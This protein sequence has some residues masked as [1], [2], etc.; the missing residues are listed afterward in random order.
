MNMAQVIVGSKETKTR[1][2]EKVKVDKDKSA[3][4]CEVEDSR[5]PFGGLYAYRTINYARKSS[6]LLIF[7]ALSLV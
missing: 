6:D 3:M 5:S 7:L 4:E 2:K 1:V